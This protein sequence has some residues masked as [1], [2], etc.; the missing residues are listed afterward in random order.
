MGKLDGRVAF[1][2]GA[3]H[4]FG[5]VCAKRLAGLGSKIAVADLALPS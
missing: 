3:A 1:V 5:R 2:T 4:G